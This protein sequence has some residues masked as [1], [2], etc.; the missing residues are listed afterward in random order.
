LAQDYRYAIFALESP[1]TCGDPTTFAFGLREDGLT[2]GRGCSL[3]SLA[4]PRPDLPIFIPPYAEDSEAFDVNETGGA[5]GRRLDS[6]QGKW[7]AASYTRL[8]AWEYLQ[9]AP[10]D[11]V[12]IKINNAGDVIGEE[13]GEFEFQH[14]FLWR[15]GQRI[16]IGP[17]QG[18]SDITYANDINEDGIIVGHAVMVQFGV[19]FPFMWNNGIITLLH[20]DDEY[21]GLAYAINDVGYAAGAIHGAAESLGYYPILWNVVTGEYTF[22]DDINH[23]YSAIFRAMN[24]IN[25]CVGTTV[26]ERL[27]SGYQGFY[28]TE[29]AGFLLFEDIIP[30]NHGWYF[31]WP[32]EIND[33]GQIAGYGVRANMSDHYVG[34]FMSPINAAF[35][36]ENLSPGS[37][38]QQN[39]LRATGLSPGTRVYF[40]YGFNGGGTLIPGCDLQDG[41]VAI[42]K[43]QV[44]GSAVADGSGVA[45]L[46]RFIPASYSGR[47]VILQ[48]V[49]QAGCQVSNVIVQTIQ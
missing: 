36:H 17:L 9:G 29:Q 33:A 5:C 15:G 28:W 39:T 16:P 48:A 4:W 6:F 25:E 12:A 2:V 46:Q 7:Y 45:T 40:V 22:I 41:A 49:N 13:D 20:H 19:K 38:G 42:E 21:G 8:D 31:E 3:H 14:A 30:D 24:N 37:A 1:D 26:E 44:I 10:E 34:F 32:F 35:T 11:S 23:G 43:A 18:W 47:K 27:S